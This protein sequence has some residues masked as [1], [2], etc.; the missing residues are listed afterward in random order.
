MRQ[1]QKDHAGLFRQQLGLGFGKTQ[2]ARSGMI[3]EFWKD[4]GK[5]L[6][7]VLPG[8]DGHQLRMRMREQ[9]AHQFFAGVTRSADNRDLLIF[10]KHKKTPP[11]SASGALQ[12]ETRN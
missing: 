4:L 9:Q 3:G 6:A 11:G 10:H 8:S 5:G 1:G 2:A 7:G 12:I